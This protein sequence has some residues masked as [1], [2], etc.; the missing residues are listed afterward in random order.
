MNFSLL[1]N[2]K[3]P[4]IVGIF[5]F[6]CIDNFMCGCKFLPYKEDAFSEVDKKTILKELSPLKVYRLS[7]NQRNGLND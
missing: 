2:I 6:I 5:I 3:M 7:L 4:T 1:I